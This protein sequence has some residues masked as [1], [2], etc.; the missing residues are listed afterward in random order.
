MSS[1]IADILSDPQARQLEFGS[2]N[3]LRFPVQTAVKTG[4]SSAY[5]DAWAVGFDS[6]YTAGVWVGNLDQ[7]PMRGI[8]GSTGA[9][10]LLRAV[11]AELN[12]DQEPQ[13]LPLSPRLVPARI[14]RLSGHLAGSHCPAMEEWF[15]PDKLPREECHQHDPAQPASGPDLPGPGTLVPVRLLRPTPGLQLAMDPHIPDELEAFPLALPPELAS[16]RVEW[17]IDGRLVGVTEHRRNQFLWGL[18]RG[19]HNARARVWIDGAVAPI[20]TQAIDFIVK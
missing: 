12:K 19:R 10:L 2:G 9:A 1:L 5:H 18:T 8:T 16:Q 15:E 4:T 11:M 6:R 17:L 13:P 14:C 7:T 3:L 20:S